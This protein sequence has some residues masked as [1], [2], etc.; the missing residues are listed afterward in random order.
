MDGSI[1]G[2]DKIT[3]R[4]EIYLENKNNVPHYLL[5]SFDIF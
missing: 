1:D 3:A 2:V 4:A 5:D